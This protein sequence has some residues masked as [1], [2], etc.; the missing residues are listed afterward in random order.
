MVFAA[1]LLC[2][3]SLTRGLLDGVPVPASVPAPL[4]VGAG[5]TAG[6]FAPGR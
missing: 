5:L 6:V 2:L 4:S 3:F 1:A